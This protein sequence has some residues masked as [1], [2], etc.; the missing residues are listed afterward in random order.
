[1]NKATRIILLIIAFLL[2]GAGIAAGIFAIVKGPESELSEKNEETEAEYI[3]DLDDVIDTTPIGELIKYDRVE[4]KLDEDG[5]LT[6]RIYYL[7]DAYAGRKDYFRTE[8]EEHILVFD[9][10]EKEIASTLMSF[11]AAGSVST[12]THR[13]NSTVTKTVEYDYYEDMT[14]P[15]N[16]L[17]KIYSGEDVFATKTFYYENGKMSEVNEYKNNELTSRIVYDENGNPIE[18]G[19]E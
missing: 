19:G 1:M 18:N 11:N 16:K 9:A 13:M 14:T 4:E 17:V 15:E 12:V 2:I 5:L 6:S 8:T 10:N 7:G 3:V